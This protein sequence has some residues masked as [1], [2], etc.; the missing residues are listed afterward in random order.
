[1]HKMCQNDRSVVE[2]FQQKFKFPKGSTDLHIERLV[3]VA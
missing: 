1:M 3:P 2:N